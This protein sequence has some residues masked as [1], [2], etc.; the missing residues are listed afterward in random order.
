MHERKLL[1]QLRKQINT[2]QIIVVT[3][4]RRTGK[5]TLCKMLFEQITSKNKIFL[6]IDNPLDQKIFEEEDYNNI[7]KN[8]EKYGLGKDAKSYIFLDEIQA[9]PEIVR[10]IKYL[11]D[12]YNIKFFVTGSSSFYLKNLFPESLAGR[13]IIFELYPLD[14]EEF[15]IFHDYKKNFYDSFDEKDK[16]KNRIE[17]EKIKKMYEEYVEYGGF[18]E[19]VLTKDNEQKKLL[20]RDIFKSYFEK[21]V[22]LIADFKNINLFR[23]LL[24][25]LLP[26]IGSKLEISK[27]SV[28]L[29][30]SRE[31]IYSYL[32]F[33][34]GTYVI[35]L[36]TPFTKSVDRE[37][38]GSRKIYFCD[39]GFLT[40]I[41]RVN[42]GQLIENAAF[43]NLRKY[44]KL[45]Y[46]QKRN[47]TEIDFILPE[48]KIAFEIKQTGT[49]SDLDKLE[50]HAK[51]LN[52]KKY[53]VLTKNFMNENKCVPLIE[54]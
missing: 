36:V 42:E 46:Y 40:Q 54:V 24:L 51:S 20:L 26:R 25:L 29:G 16:K 6:D 38:S 47:G 37:I 12:H 13:K 48:Q 17:Y 22:Q 3:G 49:K 35:F 21:D 43:L 11:Y 34:E 10:A 50:K 15:L 1:H 45:H 4:M 44:G 31:T 2:K 39:N 33:L 14:F 32:S 52:F 19:V 7:W 53:Y 41:S 27:L 28:E 23:D 9:K 5:T 30:V 8:L 18:P